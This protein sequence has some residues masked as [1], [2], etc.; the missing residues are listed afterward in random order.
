MSEP[1]HRFAGPDAGDGQDVADRVLLRHGEGV[2]GRAVGE[3][4]AEGVSGDGRPGRELA[5]A[6][7]EEVAARGR[8]VAEPQLPRVRGRVPE[9]VVDRAEVAVAQ[10]QRGF[11]GEIGD[12]GQG[13][14]AVQDVQEPEVGADLRA[15]VAGVGDGER[16]RPG[17]GGGAVITLPRIPGRARCRQASL[18]SPLVGAVAA[19][20]ISSS[21]VVAV[22]T[23]RCRSISV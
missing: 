11:L 22:L 23:R 14:P 7:V 17:G 3:V 20:A 5:G 21:A 10:Q 2:E 4:A 9:P 12:A 15:D 18:A 13:G 8:G 6:A 19:Q 16:G 1:G